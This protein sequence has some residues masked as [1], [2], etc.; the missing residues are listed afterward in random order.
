MLFARTPGRRKVRLT[1]YQ[2]ILAEVERL[3]PAHRTLGDWSLA[4]ICHHLADTQEISLQDPASDPGAASLSRALVGR[5]ALAV[6]LW[7]RTI[8]ERQLDVSPPRSTDL[9]EAIDRLR[10]SVERIATRPFPAAHPI[11][12]RLSQ[13]QWR[14]FHIYHAAHHLSFVVPIA[15]S[16]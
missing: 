2:E 13:G 4:Q 12:G 10:G 15:E 7:F 16:S 11:F 9:A 6:L 1:S 3:A 14:R 8:P 5:L